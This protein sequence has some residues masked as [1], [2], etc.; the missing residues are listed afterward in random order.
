MNSEFQEVLRPI[1]GNLMEVPQ[2]TCPYMFTDNGIFNDFIEVSC[3]I[4]I[5]K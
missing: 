1:K 4:F 5:C 2:N 3:T